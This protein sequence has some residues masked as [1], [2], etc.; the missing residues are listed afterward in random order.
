LYFYER[1]KIRKLLLVSFLLTLGFGILDVVLWE[2]GSITMDAFLIQLFIDLGLL[3][4]FVIKFSNSGNRLS[5]FTEDVKPHFNWKEIVLVIII[6]LLI[7]FGFIFVIVLAASYISPDS[8]NAILN[9]DSAVIPEVFSSKLYYFITA[10]FLAPIVEEI[11]FRGIILNRL[12]VRWGTGTAIIVSSVLFGILHFRMAI[13]GAVVFGVCMSLVYL[14]TRK[15]LITITIHFINN[16]F[17][18]IL[19]FLPMGEVDST[20]VLTL[21]DA[22]TLGFVMGI[23]FTILS[24]ILLILYVKK[25]WP[26][27]GA[28]GTAAGGKNIALIVADMQQGMFNIPGHPVYKADN[29]LDNISKLID[30]AR[31]AKIPVI[32]IQHS[33]ISKGILQHG[34][35][36]W[37][38]HE[39]IIPARGDMIIHKHSGDVFNKTK[40]QQELE[41]RNIGH[42]VLTGLQTEYFIDTTCRRAAGLG[43]NVVLVSDGHS[44]FEAP[45][46]TAEQII[47]HHNKILGNSYVNVR[48]AEEILESGF[49]EVVR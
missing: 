10:V 18:S 13:V 11:V 3:I 37:R 43:Y 2:F 21:Q 34:S 29:L 16:F 14:R 9:D 26:R 38:I 45:H 25:N 30:K 15:I 33:S 48:S 32:Y 36:G 47:D 35:P 24:T 31:E 17:A 6:H 4:W 5:D 12:R 40:L 7:T 42:I 8:I 23:P 44:T 22:R 46:L 19:M 39:S 49:H 27:K 41:F 28:E 20:A 1:I